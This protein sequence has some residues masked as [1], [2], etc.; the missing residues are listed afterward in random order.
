ME[1]EITVFLTTPEA[2]M[3]RNYQ[4]FHDTFALMVQK[5]VFD[6]KGGSVTIHFDANGIIQKIER[7]DNLFDARVKD[8]T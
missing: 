4:Q 6:I 8:L 3:F 2:M 1:Q 7:K 5:G